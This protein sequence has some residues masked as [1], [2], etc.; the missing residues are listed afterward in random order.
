MNTD[1]NQYILAIHS[2]DNHFGF[3][4]RKPNSNSSDNFFIKKF[5]KDLCNHLITDLSHFFPRDNLQKVNRISISI[6]PANFNA[7]RLIVVLA[8][9]LSQQ[10]NCS[11]D[12]FSSFQLMAKRIAL[13]HSLCKKNQSFWIFKKLKRRGYI[14]GQYE[15][16][17]DDTIKNNFF[18]KEKIEPRIF[19]KLSNNQ[20]NIEADYDIKK[21]LEELLFLSNINLKKSIFNSWEKVLPLYPLSPIN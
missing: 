12:N 20:T 9:N 18:I 4:Y 3:A 7:S 13:H 16:C 19:E 17:I 8:R 10:I 2:T 5:D 6:G 11:L 14:A 21:D 1:L 15:V